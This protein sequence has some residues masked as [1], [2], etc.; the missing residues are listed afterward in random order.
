M[1]RAV[2]GRTAAGLANYMKA[3]GLKSIVIGRDARHG[4]EDF[5]RETAEIM[6]W[7]WHGSFRLASSTTNSSSSICNY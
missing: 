7:R 1:N 3:R 2:V 5:T 6:Q 4:S